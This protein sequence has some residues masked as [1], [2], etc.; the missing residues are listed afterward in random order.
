[1]KLKF[2]FLFLFIANFCA[3]QNQK[4]DSIINKQILK[5][6]N[7]EIGG[8]LD[9]AVPSLFVGTQIKIVKN[10]SIEASYGIFILPF[11]FCST[12]KIG[13]VKYFLTKKDAAHFCKISIE[14]LSINRDSKTPFFPKFEI[15]V[16]GNHFNLAVGI[17]GYKN[18][19]RN[20]EYFH[21]TDKLNYFWIPSISIYYS[22]F[23]FKASTKIGF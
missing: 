18:N 4:V 6:I 13:F 1:M 15:G 5:P 11:F 23:L 17:G 22:N 3:A 2:L 8:Q 20:S 7:L 19:N 21:N 14:Q 16:N 9:R 10:L 12:K